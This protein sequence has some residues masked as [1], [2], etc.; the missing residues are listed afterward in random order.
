MDPTALLIMVSGI[1]AL[2]ALYHPRFGPQLYRVEWPGY[3]PDALRRRTAY[4]MCVAFAISIICAGLALLLQSTRQD[5]LIIA[6]FIPLAVA[7]VSA[8]VGLAAAVRLRRRR[9]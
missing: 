5:P 3:Q 2:V 4:V 8:F 9:S 7:F 1:T 6:S